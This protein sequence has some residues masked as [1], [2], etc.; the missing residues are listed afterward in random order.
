MAEENVKSVA[1][2]AVVDFGEGFKLTTPVS[3]VKDI[4]VAYNTT[5]K[6][7]ASVFDGEY[8]VMSIFAAEDE[9]AAASF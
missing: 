7:D 9:L 4:E 8:P 3:I 6:K 1:T 5:G 2:D